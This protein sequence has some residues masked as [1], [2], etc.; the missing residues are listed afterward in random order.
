MRQ[1]QVAILAAAVASVFGNT[2]TCPGMR[3]DP[4]TGMCT[5]GFLGSLANCVCRC[6]DYA[7][8]KG[9]TSNYYS[10]S[11]DGSFSRGD[12]LCCEH[13]FS[14]KEKQK[15]SALRLPSALNDTKDSKDLKPPSPSLPTSGAVKEGNIGA[16]N[17]TGTGSSSDGWRNLNICKCAGI[18]CRTV[19]YK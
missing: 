3:I 15:E 7:I 14:F 8:S 18:N 12:C 11:P 9:W 19:G 1:H 16:G 2:C 10:Y 17:V 4:F 5:G 6:N 13:D